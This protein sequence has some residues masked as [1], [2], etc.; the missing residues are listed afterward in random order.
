[1]SGIEEKRIVRSS[2]C[3]HPQK[4]ITPLL[5]FAGMISSATDALQTAWTSGR[6]VRSEAVK[7][8]AIEGFD[9][10]IRPPRNIPCFDPLER[11]CPTTPT[12]PLATQPHSDAHYDGILRA[13][14]VRDALRPSE[15]SLGCMCGHTA[16]TDARAGWSMHLLCRTFSK[17]VHRHT[18]TTTRSS[19]TIHTSR[20]H[21]MV[22]SS[23]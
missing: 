19:T 1:M 16:V 10:L 8:Q 12:T 9:V 21:R 18:S 4:E 5:R 3:R 11:S 17:M 20:P 22:A 14:R 13:L 2:L 6:F 15:V 23:A 7:M